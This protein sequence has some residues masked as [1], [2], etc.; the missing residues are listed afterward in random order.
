VKQKTKATQRSLAHLRRNGWQSAIVEKWIAPRGKMK[1][2]VRVDVWGFG[3]ILAC[4][5]PVMLPYLVGSND[6]KVKYSK[7]QIALIQT[8]PLA[9]W[10]D[11]WEKLLRI[12]ELKTW[13]DAGGMVIMHGWAFK[14][15]DG[16]R[17]A[18]KTWQLREEVL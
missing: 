4:R 11:H 16:I 10:K 17:G 13:Q 8:F 9:R 15:K 6:F 3:D 12:T 5:P 14:P 1:F 2:G 18:R 7:P